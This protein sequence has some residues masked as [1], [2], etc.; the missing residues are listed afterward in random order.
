MGSAWMVGRNEVVSPHVFLIK[1]RHQAFVNNNY[2]I[3]D[4]VSHQA[5]VVDP[6]WEMDKIQ[7]EL[8]HAQATLSGILITHSHHDHINLAKPMA[9]FYNCPIWM[10]QREIQSSGFSSRHL[11][12][13]DDTA[14]HVG[15][16]SIQPILTPGHTPGCVCFLIGN[17]L[18]SG[19]VL[20]AEGCGICMDL[21]SAYAMFDSLEL[22]KAVIK[23][24]THVFPGHTYMRS[25]GQ[26]FGDLLGYNIYLNFPDK[27]AFAAFRLRKGQKRENL[28]AFR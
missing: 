4:P 24:D 14:F 25:P 9:D 18:F 27:Y 1:V 16:L 12:A 2:L 3:V 10:S 8:E 15:G 21:E 13:L 28:L 6:A 7:V 26:N 17:N 5:V 11:I 20:F 19:D 23:P 22:L